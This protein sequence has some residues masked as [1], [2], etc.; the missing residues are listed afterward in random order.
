[1]SQ[2]ERGDDLIQAIGDNSIIKS[3]FHKPSFKGIDTL[4][5]TT[6]LAGIHSVGGGDGFFNHFNFEGLDDLSVSRPVNSTLNKSGSLASL[7][8][9]HNEN[10]NL[11]L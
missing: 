4:A 8:T 7:L 2:G 9:I 5:S 11:Q 6:S 3:A 1:M 10:M